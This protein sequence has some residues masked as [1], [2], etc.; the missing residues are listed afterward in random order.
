MLHGN[1]YSLKSWTYVTLSLDASFLRRYGS[2]R[3]GVGH[4]SKKRSPI[5]FKALVCTDRVGASAPGDSHAR[6]LMD[7]GGSWDGGQGEGSKRTAPRLKE[8]KVGCGT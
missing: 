1:A 7:F 4:G 2:A 8:I 3:F 6:L 5:R